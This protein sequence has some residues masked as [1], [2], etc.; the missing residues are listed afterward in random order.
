[1]DTIEQNISWYK[2]ASPELY[3][4]LDVDRN[5]CCVKYVHQYGVKNMKKEDKLVPYHKVFTEIILFDSFVCTKV[6]TLAARFRIV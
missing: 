6:Y 4:T 5:W 1:M 3:Q 2:E